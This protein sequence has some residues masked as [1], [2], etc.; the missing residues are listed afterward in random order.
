MSAN[1]LHYDATFRLVCLILDGDFTP[2]NG[3]VF[4]SEISQA[5][6]EDRE[7]SLYLIQQQSLESVQEDILYYT[8]GM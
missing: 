4:L 7:K 1:H 8:S 3:S 5:D 6:L 2:L